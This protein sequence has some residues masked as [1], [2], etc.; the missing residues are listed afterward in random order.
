MTQNEKEAPKSVQIKLINTFGAP[1]R[2]WEMS[3]EGATWSTNMF[4][5]V[6]AM[7]DGA[8]KIKLRIPALDSVSPKTAP[9]KSAVRSE[10]W[11]LPNKA[12]SW[13]DLIKFK[14]SPK[15]IA[16]LKSRG[17]SVQKIEDGRSVL[18]LD[19]YP[20]VVTRMPRYPKLVRAALRAARAVD[21]T[22][23]REPNKRFSAV[24]LLQAF[25]VMMVG[26]DSPVLD[27]DICEFGPYGD[28]DKEQWRQNPLSAVLSIDMKMLAGYI[29]PDDGSVV[30]SHAEESNFRLSTVWTWGDSSHPV[31]GN[32]EFGFW[33]QP[34]SGKNFEAKGTQQLSVPGDHT[35]EVPVYVFYTR[36]ADRP[37]P[38][39]AGW[40]PELTL[41]SGHSMWKS[42]Q[43]HFVKF[44]NTNGGESMIPDGTMSSRHPWLRTTVHRI[45]WNEVGKRARKGNLNSLF[46]AQE[47]GS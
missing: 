5:T 37:G 7:S 36:G 42:F 32:R 46:E 33:F 38:G 23:V 12:D 4:G 19:Y 8:K 43:R 3:V 9:A 14:P 20:V 47:N 13:A 25:R 30:C 39:L 6:L 26:P 1:I 24:E 2:N 15:I 29:N 17:M 28:T 11:K 16:K 21:P 31:N 10:F 44:I 27:T 34:L 45:H 18:N 22:S 40:L 41:N 35:L